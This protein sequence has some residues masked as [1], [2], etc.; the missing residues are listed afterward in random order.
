MSAPQLSPEQISR[1]LSDGWS[2]K[3]AYGI[4]AGGRRSSWEGLVPNGPVPLMA[5]TGTMIAAAELWRIKGDKKRA[6]VVDKLI[7]GDK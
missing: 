2:H 5:Q 6:G 3:E 4:P 7:A 1:R